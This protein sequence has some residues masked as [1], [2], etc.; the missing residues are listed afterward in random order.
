MLNSPL[1]RLLL[2]V[3]T[4]APLAPIVHAQ[5]TA[6]SYNFTTLAG[7]SNKGTAD[8]TGTA[9]QF[10]TPG[11]LAIDG[12]GNLIVADGS[13][14]TIRKVTPAGVV[15]TFIGLAGATVASVDGTGSAARFGLPLGV[16]IDGAGTLYVTDIFTSSIRKV[17]P[18]GVVTT[19]AGP[20]GPL[21]ENNFGSADGTG[22]AARFNFPTALVLD[23]A[24]NLFV[25]DYRNHTIRKVT[26]AGVVTTF[27]GSAGNA[28]S[29]NGT[30]TAARFTTPRDIVIDGAGNLYVAEQDSNTIRKITPDAVV[31]TFAGTAGTS[32]STNATGA[33]ARFN[34]PSGLAIDSAGNLYVGDLD[35]FAIRKITS[36]GVVTTLAGAPGSR[37]DTNGTGSAARFRGPQSV[38]VDSEGNVY[39]SDSDNANIR[40]ITPA[41]VVTTLAGQ[42]KDSFSFGSTNGTGT[43]ARFSGPGKVAVD[44]AGNVYVTDLNNDTVRKIT[45]AGV[46]T[47]LAGQAGADGTADGTGAAAR[48]NFLAGITVDPTGNVFVTDGTRVRKITPAGVVTTF[49]GGASGSVNGT[50]TAARFS[51]LREIASDSDGNLYVADAGN[52]IIRKITPDAVVT[53]FAGLSGSRGSAD[54]TTGARFNSPEGIAVDAAKNV[55]VGDGEGFLLRKITPAGVVTTLAGVPED[56]LG[57]DGVGTA[58]RFGGVTG[59]AV[60]FAGNIIAGDYNDYTIRLITPAGVVTTVAGSLQLEGATD[61]PGANARFGGPRGVAVDSLGNLYVADTDTN[62]VRKGALTI[63]PLIISQPAGLSIVAG[64][65][66]TLTVAAAG[67]G[68]TYQW[69]KDNVAI[70]GAT[71]ASYTVT[72]ASAASAG[73]YTVVITNP[74]GTVT[75]NVATLALVS[76]SAAGR[77]INLSILTSLA[78][79]GDFTM[80]YVVGGGGTSGAKPLVIRVAGP[81]LT[82]LGVTGALD[83]PQLELFAGSTSTQRNDNWGGGAAL[84]NAMAAVGAF[85]F[86]SPTS[87]D[88]AAA[89]DITTRDNSVKVTV[90]GTGSG[91]VI[92]ELYEATPS[93]NFTETTP[94]LVNVSVLKNIGTGLTMGFVVGG[95]TSQTVLVRAIGPTL[96]AAPFNI[97][98]VVADPQLALFSGQTKIN[99]NN[100]WGGTAALT[101]AFTQVG[102]F[103]LPAASR[104]AAILAT[105]EPG[106]Y[107]VQVTGVNATSGTAIIEVYEVR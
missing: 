100:D 5:S 44:S 63:Q 3:A 37:G 12:A 88:A 81:S 2:A 35:N 30:G 16:A 92:A 54:G 103:A 85:A 101:A 17:T 99:E 71:G 25:T 60:D 27:A 21:N 18:A 7:R 86:A 43:A 49:A 53:T 83:D 52:H 6:F 51:N 39:V 105:L 34:S 10:N 87:R 57:R 68:N 104:D 78:A 64:G 47:T 75:S 40:K 102:A 73:S 96:G 38:T 20:T 29:T 48:F 76:A 91:A 1:I 13:S 55:Y 28:G 89:V 46:V 15:T 14:N 69:R 9:A 36:A 84:T 4:F 32:G 93:A 106:S 22:S 62:T 74:L 23:G 26:P 107:T 45:P 66:A 94:R 70:A 97:A 79:G 8:G 82:Q 19:L 61:G 58:A 72:N 59:L 95:S 98:G 67:A 41:G 50:G 56:S 24:G 80:G 42:S 65:T 31:T 90:V 77:L 33:A 11:G